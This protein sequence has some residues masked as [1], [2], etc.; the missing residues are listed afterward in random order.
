M[1]IF[2]LKVGL[3]GAS[4]DSD[5]TSLLKCS[6]AIDNLVCDQVSS[7]CKCDFPFVWNGVNLNCNDLAPGYNYS[8][9][10]LSNKNFKK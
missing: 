4:C 6:S 3:E 10:V 7:R 8:N 2:S 5:P 1:N 9:G